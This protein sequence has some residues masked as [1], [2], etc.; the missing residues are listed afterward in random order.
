VAQLRRRLEAGGE[1]RLLHT[2]RGMGYV[3]EAPA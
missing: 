1:P 3:L 2:R